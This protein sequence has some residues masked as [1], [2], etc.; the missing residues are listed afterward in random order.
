MKASGAVRRPP[1]HCSTT[2]DGHLRRRRRR[3]PLLVFC[4]P[5]TSHL[6]EVWPT[7]PHAVSSPL[8]TSAS[9]DGGNCVRVVW[10]TTNELADHGASAV[11]SDE[12]FE[13][14]AYTAVGIQAERFRPPPARVLIISHGTAL[15]LRLPCGLTYRY[16]WIH[17]VLTW[18]LDANHR[19][20]CTG[21]VASSMTAVH[22]L[23]QLSD[24]INFTA[25]ACNW[26]RFRP[27]EWRDV[28]SCRGTGSGFLTREWPDPTRPVVTSREESA[29]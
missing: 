12:L 6:Y 23:L 10:R 11:R 1:S 17:D 29:T 7:S 26:P 2:G 9:I 3:C 5:T 18:L 21:M 15:M 24:I 28:M 19:M 22:R 8:L 20:Q 13:S 16:Y 27:N 25:Y 4:L 14:D